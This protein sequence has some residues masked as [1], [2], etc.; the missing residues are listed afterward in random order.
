MQIQ[1]EKRGEITVLF[2][3]GNLDAESVP[4]F[5]KVA[6]KIVE[7]GC[8]TLVVECQKLD[9]IDSMGLGAMISLLR[10]VR[11]QKGDLKISSLKA[12]V[13]SVFEITRL[14][15]LFEILP[16]LASACEKFKN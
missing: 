12:D 8:N 9:F 7:E 16:D 4:Q 5:K 10:K 1:T 11:T 3:S 2:M 15:N 6:N 13:R 14:H